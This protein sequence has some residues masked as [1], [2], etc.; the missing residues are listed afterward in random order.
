MSVSCAA[1]PIYYLLPFEA[2]F[3]GLAFS[4]FL[5]WI[6][7]KQTLIDELPRGPVFKN[8]YYTLEMNGDPASDE[9]YESSD[10]LGSEERGAQ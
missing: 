10:S 6:L 4:F 8:N 3:W 9:D 2:V 1:S 7:V 5:F